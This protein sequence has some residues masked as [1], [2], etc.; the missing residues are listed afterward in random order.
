[1]L[2]HSFACTGIGPDGDWTNARWMLRHPRG[3]LRERPHDIDKTQRPF[4]D[5]LSAWS[6]PAERSGR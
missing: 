5:N 6:V 2:K 4:P 1:M 3:G